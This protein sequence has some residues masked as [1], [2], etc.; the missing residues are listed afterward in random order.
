M[1]DTVTKRLA[2]QAEEI[3]HHRRKAS[4]WDTHFYKVVLGGNVDEVKYAV[5]YMTENGMAECLN[6]LLKKETVQDI[7][8]KR[9]SCVSAKLVLTRIC[10]FLCLLVITLVISS[11]VLHDT[12]P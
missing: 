7:K 6:W 10:M 1:D 9:C 8:Y 2:K 3:Y 12:H 4:R 11:C 5:D